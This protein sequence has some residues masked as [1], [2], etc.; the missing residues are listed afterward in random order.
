LWRYLSAA[1]VG[2]TIVGAGL[3][4]E[5]VIP[6]S[7]VIVVQLDRAL[8]S[9][10]AKAGETFVTHCPGPDCGGFPAKTQFVGTVTR[11]TPKTDRAP[12]RLEVAFHEAILPDGTTKI[13]MEATIAPPESTQ[14]AP[15]QGKQGRAGRGLAGAMVG[16]AV[17][18]GDNR[19]G[20]LVGACVGVASS[21]SQSAKANA[22]K[23]VEIT[24]G[25]KF[26]IKLS[27]PVTLGGEK[28]APTPAP[29]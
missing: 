29:T 10:H 4:S 8:S 21:A 12:G 5:T 15:K 19:S 6:K 24:A 3:A 9:K 2:A 26:R 20:A 28:P 17:S 13:P 22:P 1:V 11:V 23:D 16:A 14:S 27:K 25:S 7:T 18:R